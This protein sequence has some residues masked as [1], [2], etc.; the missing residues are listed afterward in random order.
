MT[1]RKIAFRLLAILSLVPVAFAA[2]TQNS[3]LEFPSN[4]VRS[5]AQGLA[6]WLCAG[7]FAFVVYWVR[8]LF[9]RPSDHIGNILWATP[10]A[11][12]LVML[13]A[14]SIHLQRNILANPPALNPEAQIIRDDATALLTAALVPMGVAALCQRIVEENQALFDAAENF[15][16]RHS[17]IYRRVVTALR[18]NG[19][20]RSASQDAIQE[21]TYRRIKVDIEN[22]DDRVSFCRSIPSLIESGVF[23]LDKREDMS[24]AYRR[25]ENAGY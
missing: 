5:W 12:V 11:M 25:F 13:S 22:Q 4:Y 2:E 23:D 3:Y 14:F 1:K 15:N 16:E 20:F 7:I 18:Q 17:S 21:Q 8:R 24:E 9:K 10:V 6:P 19:G